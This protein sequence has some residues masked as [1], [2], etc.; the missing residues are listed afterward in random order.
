MEGNGRRVFMAGGGNIGIA[1]AMLTAFI[2]EQLTPR[3]NRS[4]PSK[5]WIRRGWSFGPVPG[6]GQS[7]RAR[8]SRQLAEGKIRNQPWP[9]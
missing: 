7:E 6:G 3:R 4:A 9:G 8:R 1:A 5:N 2:S